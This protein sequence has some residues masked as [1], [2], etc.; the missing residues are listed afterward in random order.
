[1][2]YVVNLALVLDS[3]WIFAFLVAWLAV[4]SFLCYVVADCFYA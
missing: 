3:L 4:V 2:V 1:M